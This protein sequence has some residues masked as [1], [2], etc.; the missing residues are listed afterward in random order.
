GRC[1]RLAGSRRDGVEPGPWPRCLGPAVAG[2]RA[3]NG[4]DAE[5][6]DRA[7]LHR[8][9]TPHGDLAPRRRRGAPRGRAARPARARARDRAAAGPVTRRGRPSPARVAALTVGVV[10][11]TIL[12]PVR[13]ALALLSETETVASIL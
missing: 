10:L 8:R 1:N 11:A 2:L 4:H 9:D 5:R 13:P 6:A 7:V 3:G 12:S